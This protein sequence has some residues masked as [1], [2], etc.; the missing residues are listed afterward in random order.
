[1][2]DENTHTPSPNG[3]P[4]PAANPQ[5]VDADDTGPEAAASDAADDG[6]AQDGFSPL[7]T[8]LAD[9]KD[10]L[11]RAMA[12]A[13]NTRKRAEREVADA[14]A[15]ALTSFAGDLIQVADNLDRAIH[16]VTPDL[17]DGLGDAGAGLLAGIE[18]T[19][20]ELLDALA[21]Q[22]IKPID[23]TP[24]V[25]FDPNLHQAVAQIP[26]DHPKDC[27]VD[28]VQSG[29]RIGDRT[30]RAAM[31]AVSAGPADGAPPSEP[32]A[33]AVSEAASDT[34]TTEDDVNTATPGQRLDT[35]I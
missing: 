18:M 14:K 17:R 3:D 13:E 2:S 7:E 15:Y 19:R 1:M 4:E 11:M 23:S 34:E 35:T 10:R 29:W 6:A 30:L 31:V 27:I 8:E 21:R 28:A 20:K 5:A 26:S 32:D 16:A 24:G 22:H 33:D 25:R 9:M 12:D